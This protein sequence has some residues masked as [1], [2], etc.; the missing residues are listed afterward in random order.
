[1]RVRVRSRERKKRENR[2][3]EI[4]RECVWR[5]R[6][7]GVIPSA[8][9]LICASISLVA[10]YTCV[11]LCGRRSTHYDRSEKKRASGWE[12]ERESVCVSEWERENEVE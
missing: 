8:H 3:R 10:V 4:E 5:K 12:R 6:A 7:G 2:E 1:M 9:L 11:Y